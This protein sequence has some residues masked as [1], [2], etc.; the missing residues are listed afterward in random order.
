MSPQRRQ[1]LVGSCAWALPGLVQAAGKPL[2][3]PRDHGAH[4]EVRIEWWYATGWLGRPEA[5]SHGFQVT[6][7]RSAT[8]LASQVKSR[9]A[10]R[11]LLFAHAALTTLPSADGKLQGSH[12]HDQRIQRWSGAPG[13]PLAHAA[14]EDAALVLGNWTLRRESGGWRAELPARS[15]ALSVALKSTQPLLLQGE[16]GYSRKGPGPR[17]ASHYYSDVQLQASVSF[18]DETTT[19]RTGTSTGRAW[20]DHEWSDQLL[21]P[22][23]VGWDWLGI[24][25][26]DGSALT[27]FVLRRIDGSSLWA[28]GSFRSAAGELQNFAPQQVRLQPLRQ[29]RSPASGA[30]YPVQWRVS[31]PAGNFG[32]QALLDEQE[33]DSSASTGAVYWEGLSELTDAGGRRLGLGYLEMTGYARALRLP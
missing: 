27:V 11:H 3:F 16:A 26:F 33:L 25:L 29:W 23:A 21:H 31:C 13:A 12:R 32:L 28:G 4:L 19:S 2:G 9:F 8:G 17:E 7:F 24:N 15:F 5:P 22:Q 1:W 6:F 14:T 18:K 20:L 10:A 30:R